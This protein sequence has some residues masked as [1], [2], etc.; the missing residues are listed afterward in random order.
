MNLLVWLAQQTPPS[1]TVDPGMELAPGSPLMPTWLVLVFAGMVGACIGSFLNVVVWR[2]PRRCMSLI[3]PGS[4]CPSCKT[5]IR[6]YDNIPVFS[7]FLLRG[8]CRSCKGR[9]SFRYPAVEAFTAGMFALVVWLD[10]IHSGVSGWQPWLLAVTHCVFI[11]IMIAAALID[12]DLTVIPDELTWGGVAVI[13]LLAAC[14]PMH[15]GAPPPASGL[16]EQTQQ[17]P[18]FTPT[19]QMTQAGIDQRIVRYTLDDGTQFVI[20]PAA[21]LEIDGKM[22]IKAAPP[23]PTQTQALIPHGPPPIVEATRNGRTQLYRCAP[24][25]NGAGGWVMTPVSMPGA[26]AGM[27]QVAG[28][29]PASAILPASDG[30]DDAP[31]PWWRAHMRSF[32]GALFGA[33]IAGGGMWLLRGLA[34][35]MM[36]RK[37]LR[38][39]QGAAMGMGDVKLLMLSGAMIGWPGALL[40]I[41]GGAALGLIVTVP[42]L[43]L[44]K[45]HLFPFG[46]FLA[47]A[48]VGILVFHSQV[49]ALMTEYWGPILAAGR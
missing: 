12:A 27:V 38:Y 3:A 16:P 22:W 49:L 24:A 29:W 46:P 15:G 39:G 44:K 40:S 8:R 7:W 6:A 5:P 41:F 34:T 30:T 18:R 23:S 36:I 31:A 1:A 35:G 10:V 47:A 32:L 19:Y 4:H 2:L 20:Q 33:L 42:M 43:I 17:Y 48:A 21:F 9:I 13:L 26:G 11:S 28:Q 45:Q 25:P 37:A 14:S